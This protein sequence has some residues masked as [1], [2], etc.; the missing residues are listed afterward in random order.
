MG[1]VYV[2][3]KVKGSKAARTIRMLVDTG[4]TFIVLK[5]ETVEELGLH[6][7]PYTVE[8]TLADGRKVKARVYMAEVEVGRRRGPAMVV[9]VNTPTP[10]LG[11]H[12]L[13]TLGFK[14]DPTT[15]RLEEVSPEGGYLLSF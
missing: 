2:D 15:G 7:T 6:E 5:P 10:L 8:L 9:A 11:V 4:S 3:V 12:A 1:F 13:G 14:V